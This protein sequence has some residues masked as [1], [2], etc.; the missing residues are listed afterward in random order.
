MFS[1]LFQ[2]SLSTTPS[3]AHIAAI[4][5]SP[6]IRPS[7]VLDSPTGC[8]AMVGPQLLTAHRRHRNVQVLRFLRAELWAKGQQQH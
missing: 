6:M 4:Q 7:I 8:P 1:Q 2:A 3:A 5:Q